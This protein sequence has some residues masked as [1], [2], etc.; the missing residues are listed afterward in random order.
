MKKLLL[1]LLCLPLL[2]SSCRRCIDC[3]LVLEMET[4]ITINKLDSIVQTIPNEHIYTG[5]YLDWNAYVNFNY[6]DLGQE[7]RHC[8]SDAGEYE[9]YEESFWIDTIN[10]GTFYYNCK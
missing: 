8:E 6:P 5:N 1:I 2:F 4:Q 3:T 10:I 9:N 7:Q